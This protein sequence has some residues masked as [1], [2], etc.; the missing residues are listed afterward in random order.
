MQQSEWSQYGCYNKMANSECDA[1]VQQ[2][3][4]R[5]WFT[6]RSGF[7]PH[8]LFRL[9]HLAVVGQT[10]IRGGHVQKVVIT[11]QTTI[12]TGPTV[13]NRLIIKKKKNKQKKE[14]K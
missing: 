4:H 11:V 6:H 14:I 8:F 9:M 7:A 13:M 12:G 10:L 5:L 1:G 2:I 3:V